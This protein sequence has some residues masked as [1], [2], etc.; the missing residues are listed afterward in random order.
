MCRECREPFPCHRLQLKPLV[1]GPGIHHGTCV[2]HVPWCMSGPLTWGA[3]KTFPAYVQPSILRIWQEA[4]ELL[5]VT[6][7][8]RDILLSQYVKDKRDAMKE[9][10]VTFGF[11]YSIDH[12]YVILHI[13]WQLERYMCLLQMMNSEMLVMRIWQN[14]DSVARGSNCSNG[15]DQHI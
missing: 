7:F 12:Y 8:P 14:V 3:G 1:S 15:I 11:G 2:M 6:V 4:H 5:C 10:G 13:M 9:K